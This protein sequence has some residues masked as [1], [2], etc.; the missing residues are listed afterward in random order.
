MKNLTPTVAFTLLFSLLAFVSVSE[1]NA[2][3]LRES[4]KQFDEKIV[5]LNVDTNFSDIKA[6]SVYF[7]GYTEAGEQE[8]RPFDFKDEQYLSIGMVPAEIVARKNGV[9]GMSVIEFINSKMYRNVR[10]IETHPLNNGRGQVSFYS[11]LGMFTRSGFTS[12]AEEKA[13]VEVAEDFPVYVFPDRADE[14]KERQV[15][16]SAVDADYFAA[17][18][19]G[20]SE[21]IEVRYTEYGLSKPGHVQARAILEPNGVTTDGSFRINDMEELEILEAAGLV[22]LQV[23]LNEHGEQLYAVN[24]VFEDAEGAVST[25]AYL[26]I[27]LRSN[28]K[29]NPEEENWV[30]EFRCLKMMGTW[31][32]Q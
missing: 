9:D 3:S 7:D 15:R 1:L 30:E 4:S 32:Q 29:F 28:N 13:A 11:E 24:R 27:P 19:F 22:V 18:P 12:T 23:R 20:L 31:C 10:V 17:N 5:L 6:P 21:I 2:Q 14:S 16:M 26:M 25:D 8:K